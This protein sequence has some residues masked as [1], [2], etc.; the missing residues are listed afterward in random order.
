[1]WDSIPTGNFT[2]ANKVF[3][4]ATFT[5]KAPNDDDQN[6]T[7]DTIPTARTLNFP[8]G[9]YISDRKLF[10]SDGDNYRYVIF[11]F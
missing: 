8:D 1:M 4:Q 9:L 7:Q 11:N 2:P 6:G 5:A 10:V 3:G